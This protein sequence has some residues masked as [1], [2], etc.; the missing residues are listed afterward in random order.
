MDDRVRLLCGD[1]LTLMRDIPADSVLAIV[2]DPPYGIGY[3]HSGR[4]FGIP[5]RRN[6]SPIIGDAAPFDPSP[7]LAFPCL[8]WGA[9]HFAGSLPPGGSWLAWDKSV[10]QGP[11]DSFADCE[12]AWCSVSGIKRNVCRHLWKGVIR[13]RAGENDGPRLHPTQK[14][15][16]LMRWAISLLDLPPDSLILDPYMGSGSTGV[17]ALKMGHR[18]LGIEIDPTYFRVAQRRLAAAATPLFDGPAPPPLA[19]VEGEGDA[20]AA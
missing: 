1:C 14:P 20:G 18:F 11:A 5:A 9:N 3:V 4:G 8:F 19:A 12:F 6:A 16:G 7:W 2:T 15:F 10:G 13:E 17:A